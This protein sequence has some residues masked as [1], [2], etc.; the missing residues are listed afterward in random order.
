MTFR[1]QEMYTRNEHFAPEFLAKPSRSIVPIS[2]SGISRG[3]PSELESSIGRGMSFAEFQP[4]IT[5]GKVPRSFLAA[6]R[7]SA[8]H[9]LTLLPNELRTRS[10]SVSFASKHCLVQAQHPSHER[11]QDWST[12]YI[13]EERR[14]DTKVNKLIVIHVAGLINGSCEQKTFNLEFGREFKL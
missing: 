9:R 2:S 6:N 13:Y 3:T 10:N 5:R 7:S 4:E 11:I 12:R 8:D 14:R 1:L